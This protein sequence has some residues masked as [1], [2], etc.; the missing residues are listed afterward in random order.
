MSL[1]SIIS[2]RD[3]REGEINKKLESGLTKAALLV[4]R[5]AKK[6]SPVDTGTLR[7]SITHEVEPTEA[8]VGTN[9]EYS[10]FQEYGT[11]KMQ[12]HPFLGPALEKNKDQIIKLLQGG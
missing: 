6:E 10:S 3:K 9:V 8:R 4:E 11:R 2:F 12:A 5:D 7:S 1:F